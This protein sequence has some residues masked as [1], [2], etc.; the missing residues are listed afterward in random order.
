[1]PQR[2]SN[3]HIKLAVRAALL[4]LPAICA[5]ASY[6]GLISHA[7]EPVAAG[8][9]SLSITPISWNV[10]GLDS[11]SPST[12]PNRFPVGARV[13]NTGTAPSGTITAN[14]VW[15]SSNS[16]IFLRA[17]SLATVQFGTLAAGTCAD[18]Y[19]EAEVDK[20]AGSAP[21][22]TT[23][24]Y[25]IVATDAFSGASASTPAGRELFVEHLI[26]QNRNG[27]DSIK[28]NGVA[29][30]AGGSMTMVVGSTY[31]IELA[32]HTATQG[33]NQLEG[34]INFPNTI[35]QTLGVSTT[36][37]AN[38]STYV[39]TPNDKLYANACLWDDD[40]NSPNYRSCV[41]GDAKSGGTV[42]TTY[43]VKIISGGGS[44][45][46][47]SSLLYDFSGSSFHY[48]A[49]YGVGAR[50]AN[51]VSPASVSLTKSFTPRAIAPGGTSA[52][53]FKI[54]NSTGE[55]LTGVNFS[56]TFPSGLQVA[57]PTGISYSGCGAGVF[58][59]SPVAG[60]TSLSFA[61]GAIAA[62]S[63]CTITV[64]ATAP[65]VGT[66]VNTT[67]HLFINTS[68]DTG[69]F[70]QDTLTVAALAVCTPGQTLATWTMPTTGQGSG[71]PPPPYTTK[72]TSVATATAT[73]VG[74]QHSVITG[75]GNPANAWAV[76]GFQKSATGITGDTSPY[77]EFALDTSKY[78]GVAMSLDYTRD[79]NWGGGSDVPTMY[80][81]SST[82]GLPG[83]YTLIYT[84]STLTGSWQTRAGITAAVTGAATTYFRINASGVNSVNSSQLFI[85]NISFTGCGLPQPAPTIVKSF[86][87]SQVAQGT[88]TTL[89]FT[90]SNT[91][92]GN[93]AVSGI[94]V[95]DVLPSGLSVAS[96]TA[97]ACGGTLTA[98]AGT[99]T[100]ALTGGA[101]ASG[102]SCTFSMPVTGVTAGSYTN[103]TGY[104]STAEGGTSVSYATAPLTVVAPPAIGKAFA[105]GSIFTGSTTSLTFTITNPNQSTALTGVGFTD[106]LP[107][108]LTAVARG[109]TPTCGG[110]RSLASNTISLTGATIAANGTCSFSVTVTGATAGTKLNTTSAVTST[111]G[112]AGNT[113]AAT[114]IVNTATPGIDLNKQV[115]T[116]G[117]NWFKFAGVP[118]GGNVYYRFTAYNGG[119]LSF[120]GVGVNDPLL[121]GLG[122]DPAGCTWTVPLAAGGTAYCVKGPIS[123][124]IGTQVN[125]ATASGT[126]AAGVANSSAST[127]TYATASLSMA[128][129]ST[130][131]YFLAAGN[132]LHYSY[133]VTNSGSAPLLGPV[134]IADDKS[135]DENCPP[136][137]TVGDLDNYL[138][139]GESITCSATYVVQAADVT[140]QSVTNIATASAAGVTSNTASK[141]LKMGTDLSISKSS[142]VKPYV[143]GSP[144]TY[145]IVVTNNGPA[146]VTGASVTDTLPIPISGFSWTCTTA[147]AGAS[148]G[149]PGPVA[150]N[151]NALVTLPVRAQAIFALTGTVPSSATGTISNTA[152]VAPPAGVADIVPGNNS[153][154]DTNGTGP[155]ADLVI[156]KS[157][158][159][160]PFAAGAS[161][162]YTITVSNKGPA[163]V[164]GASVRDL[165]PA[166]LTNVSWTSTTTGAAVVNSG[167]TGTGNDLSANVDIG[168]AAADKVIFMVSCSVPQFTTG[169]IT[170]TA[171][172][173]PPSG[174]IDPVPGNNTATDNNGSGPSA[175]LS[176]LKS[177]TPS[178]HVAGQALAYT[179]TV[180]N[181][182]GSDVAGA[183]VQD[184]LP[185]AM[186][187]F[188]WTC[189]SNGA[190]SCVKASGSGDVD[191]LV[192]LPSGT[193]VTFT[194]SGTVPPGTTGP[195][196]NTATVAPPAGVND[197]VVS[198]N[199]STVGNSVTAGGVLIA[200]RV[201][202]AYGY[203]VQNAVV[204]LVDG[205]GNSFQTITSPM[206][207][208]F[209]EDV[210]A[211]RT[212]VLSPTAKGLSFT[213]RILNVGGDLPD[214]DLVALP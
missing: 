8:T 74:M 47:L 105:A 96:S 121:S 119:D 44:S 68:T 182:G 117:V 205:S 110:S 213:Q 135:T 65:A 59:P 17:G 20:N 200:G 184:S 48:N 148:C 195:Q 66:Y 111:E 21:Y 129:S 109:A 41:G 104:V 77:M 151:I 163:S 206:G 116:D 186:S 152:T 113:A 188:T 191:A 71:G 126:S 149:T 3:K 175:D 19:F 146:A 180:S 192:N 140:A 43:T 154:T 70:G 9:A 172:V 179:L 204:T 209:F 187:A 153:A 106:S 157:S 203:G 159:P 95:S 139:A 169:V 144:L 64:N 123:T 23:R 166:T 99:R 177:S 199:S 72:S 11:N 57:S 13:C 212:Y 53:T 22:N 79:T 138:D 27:V 160:N 103:T 75:S 7:S 38:T 42:I 164:T 51:I 194:V 181:L 210:P 115:S 45:Q 201:S 143:A 26:S 137:S 183:R 173:T 76:D 185:A 198:N 55:A 58:S 161:L 78:S 120:S 171:T 15:D 170:N 207:Y 178:Q 34:F 25:H 86:S 67:D 167:A 214:T 128:K 130:E 93:R 82:T 162:N 46:A 156:T 131:T 174:V 87:P 89:S 211:G 31:T 88:S 36:Y 90:I 92:A 142:S 81:Y 196:V 2:L 145:T 190:G 134:T 85:D 102:A 122:A 30:P 100:I 49:D 35:F 136:V 150:G 60:A 176:I 133:A 127:A 208:Y 168:P 54:A 158:S 80:V 5:F 125:T 132:I 107:S 16:Y 37:T 29:V 141:T 12:G 4:I 1:M 33:Y 69:N 108:G 62:N 52:M 32:A 73:A 14:F 24:R 83:S 98:T 39:G 101:L 197:L 91:A 97:A 165:V 61:G 118:V 124:V 10:V 50:I 40:L 189:T 84:T 193:F 155:R 63:T 112:G 202:T 94:A 147:G 18:A 114:L 28:L 6:F 56:D